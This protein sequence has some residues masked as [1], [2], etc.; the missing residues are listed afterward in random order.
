MQTMTSTTVYFISHFL[1]SRPT[2]ITKLFSKSLNGLL[3][4][5]W[6]L[7]C[8]S[9]VILVTL[10][11]TSGAID[12][13]AFALFCLK[14]PFC[15]LQDSTTTLVFSLFSD[16][17]SSSAQLDV[18]FLMHFLGTLVISFCRP[19][20]W[21]DILPWLHYPQK[22]LLPKSLSIVDLGLGCQVYIF[23]CHS[24]QLHLESVMLSQIT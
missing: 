4:F 1:V 13:S 7:T 21:V 3:V 10:S 2:K 6:I 15:G 16:C 19:P 18:M 9:T 24:T 14:N 11:I 17:S 20:R 23:N 22:E 5:Q 12:H 8:S